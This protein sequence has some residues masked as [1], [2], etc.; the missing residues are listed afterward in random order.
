MNDNRIPVVHAWFRKAENDLITAEH[1][2]S[3]V[4]PPCDT[5]CFHAQ[6]CAEKY[7]KGFLAFHAVEFPR[8]HDLED[9]VSLGASVD[10]SLPDALTG[11]ELLSG[12]GV[13]ARYPSEVYYDIPRSDAEDAV[14]LAKKV[15]AE[16]LLRVGDLGR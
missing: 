6:Q 16:I 1:T 3:M 10:P 9:L 14:V 11:V 2:L 8:T 13:E 7:L 5:I 12:Y 15:R 4:N